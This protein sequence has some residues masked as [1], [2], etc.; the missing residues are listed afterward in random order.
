M[1]IFAFD[2]VDYTEL[3]AIYAGFSVIFAKI[4]EEKLIVLGGNQIEIYESNGTHYLRRQAITA[5]GTSVFQMLIP[6]DM[7]EFIFGGNSKAFTIYEL[8]NG[9]YELIYREE[10]GETIFEV[11][12]DPEE[13]YLILE[14]DLSIR[15][16]Y[17]CPDE[18]KSCHFPNNCSACID[19]YQL[20]AGKCEYQASH[21][22][23]NQFVKEDICQEYCS[24]ECE[25]CRATKTD[26]VECA[27]LYEMNEEGKCESVTSLNIFVSIRPFL[28]V[29]R[30]RGTKWVFMMVDDL[31][32]YQYHEK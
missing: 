19:G 5:N 32:L 4:T 7:S 18:C 24:R 15:T 8:T 13:H 29:I 23:K 20:N 14:T 10:V 30:R 25:T 26:C 16:Y 22:V 31:W 12:V 3:Q 11:V 6:E 1:R 21:C 27:A 9:T 2:G 28:N 17:R